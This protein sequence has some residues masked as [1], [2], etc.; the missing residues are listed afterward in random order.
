MVCLDTNIVIYIANGVLGE[1]IVG[2][3]S[4]I[5][6]SIL[7]IES[8]GYQNIKSIEEQRIRELLAVLVEAQLTE[9]I[10]ERAIRLRQ[11]KKMTLGDAV[12]AA[13]ALEYDCELWTANATDFA[14]VEGLRIYDPLKSI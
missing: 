2:N 14:Q 3:E 10:I 13:T 8:L 7:R 1:Q 11:Q 12:V 6:P 4:I 9:G 5:Y